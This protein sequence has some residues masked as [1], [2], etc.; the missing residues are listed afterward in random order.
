MPL[1][2]QQRAA[3]TGRLQRLAWLLDSRFAVPFTGGRL[4]IGYDALIG[5]IPVVGDGAMCVLALFIVFQ[6]WR[7]GTPWPIILRMLL[8]V[9]LDLLIGSIPG[10]G[11]LAD[12]VF[13]VNLLN[14]KMI[15]LRPQPGANAPPTQPRP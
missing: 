6:A 11:D 4:R 2:S 5:L 7:L 10:I 12:A 13:K 9:G 3:V 1:S 14:L 8:L 15:G